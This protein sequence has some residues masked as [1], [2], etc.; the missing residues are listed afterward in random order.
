MSKYLMIIAGAA[1]LAFLGMRAML[2]SKEEKIEPPVEGAAA[3]PAAVPEPEPEPIRLQLDEESIERVRNSTR[4]TDPIVRWQ[5]VR[6][7]V[8]V[9]DEHAAG[10]L[11][12]MLHRDSDAGNR[13]HVVELLSEYHEPEVTRNLTRALKDTDNDVRLA[14]LDALARIGDYSAAQDIGSMIHDS[15]EGV[16]LKAITA[17]DQLE[18]LRKEQ[19]ENARVKHEKEMKRWEENKKRRQPAPAGE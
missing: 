6:F 12:A 4:D 2:A 1:M 11:F 13:R 16:R 19:I 17:L 7:L 18:R 3:A 15:H 10:A 8:N 14:V 5:A 9:E